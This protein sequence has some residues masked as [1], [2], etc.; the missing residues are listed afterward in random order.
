[1]K[2]SL[3]LIMLT[4][5]F[6]VIANDNCQSVDYPNNNSP[7]AQ[8]D[9]VKQLSNS[10]IDAGEEPL[11]QDPPKHP[12]NTEFKTKGSSGKIHYTGELT[13]E[14]AKIIFNNAYANAENRAKAFCKLMGEEGCK[15]VKFVKYDTYDSSFGSDERGSWAQV[16][17][18][19]VWKC[20]Q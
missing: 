10:L 8:T 11:P 4:L 7:F 13:D 2:K 6:Q 15:N 19:V 14:A 1:M 20:V 3:L 18:I 16:D 5:S 9:Q 12:C 17:L